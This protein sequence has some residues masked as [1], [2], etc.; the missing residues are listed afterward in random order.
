MGT[1]FSIDLP[2]DARDL[3]APA[4]SQLHAIEGRFSIYRP[5]SEISQIGAGSLAVANASCDVRRV[6]A[7]C[8][9][10]RVDPAR[11]ARAGRRRIY[12]EY[13]EHCLEDAELSDSEAAD[14]AH[15]RKILHLDPTDV[16]GVHEE[17][18]RSVY[19]RALADVL[20]DL[21]IDENERAFLQLLRSRV[22]LSEQEAD[23][24]TTQ[25]LQDA[26]A[27]AF[28]E[29]VVPDPLFSRTRTSAGEFTGRSTVG[30]EDAIQDAISKA[31][32]WIP[33]V[34][35]F[36]V[37]RTA[38]YVSEAGVRGWHVTLSVGIDPDESA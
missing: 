26:R 1:V 20:C 15:P 25:G 34:H 14:L 28:S 29:A 30:F 12:A 38:G 35:W 8:E 16:Q 37:E 23:R 22:G 36:E 2:D 4:V 31:R 21:E 33:R 3:I 11:Q 13:L 17:I 6:L 7:A 32:E 27:R 18:G 9:A 19:G 5:D 10:H 24:L